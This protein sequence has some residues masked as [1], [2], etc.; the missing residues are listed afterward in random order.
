[1][2]HDEAAARRAEH[3]VVDPEGGAESG[4]GVAGGGLDVDLLDVR[5]RS[6]SLPLASEFMAQP[7]ASASRLRPVRFWRAR[8]RAK[9]RSS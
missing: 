3:R 2:L 8:T 9:K 5:V 6:N 7:P 4:A 1:M